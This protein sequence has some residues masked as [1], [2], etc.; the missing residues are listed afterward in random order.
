M[1]DI[2]HTVVQGNVDAN[3]IGYIQWLPRLADD[4]SN[5]IGW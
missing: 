4:G 3:H 2:V 1:A 5:C